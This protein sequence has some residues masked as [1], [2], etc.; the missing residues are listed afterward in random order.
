MPSSR[1]AVAYDI[2]EKTKTQ[3]SGLGTISYDYYTDDLQ[4]KDTAVQIPVQQQH[5]RSP[6]THDDLQVTGSWTTRTVDLCYRHLL[7][8]G[9]VKSR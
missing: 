8:V 7:S 5:M 4:G 9:G 1:S 2:G 6:R 3:L